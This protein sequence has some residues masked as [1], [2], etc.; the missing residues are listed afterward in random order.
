MCSVYML[1]AADREGLAST[2]RDCGARQAR[3]MGH[4]KGMGMGGAPGVV[5]G[6]GEEGGQLTPHGGEKGGGASRRYFAMLQLAPSSP[7]SCSPRQA[8]Q[9]P[10]A[11][12]RAACRPGRQCDGASLPDGGDAAALAACGGVGRPGNRCHGDESEI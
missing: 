6:V 1:E 7:P 5:M 9:R 8:G 4:G 3:C 10:A 11:E 2:G 12:H